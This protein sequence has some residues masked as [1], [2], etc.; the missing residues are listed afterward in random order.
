MEMI[1]IYIYRGGTEILNALCVSSFYV[2]VSGCVY[3]SGETT[4]SQVKGRQRAFIFL[5]LSSAPTD[6]GRCEFFVFCDDAS[7]GSASAAY[8][9]DLVCIGRLCDILFVFISVAI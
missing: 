9:G 5:S 2:L 1:E 6:A 7:Y 4:D 3:R 8:R